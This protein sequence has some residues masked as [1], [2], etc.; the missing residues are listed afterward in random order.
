MKARTFTLLL[1]AAALAA[2]PASA[3]NGHFLHGVGAVNSA[4]GGAGVALPNDTLGALNLNPA[5]LTELDGNGYEF[6]A[7]YNKADNAVSSQVGP[8][9]GRTRESGS[10]PLIPA[11]GWT[12]HRQGSNLAYGVG[13]LGLAGF[14]VD[15]AQDPNNPIL[16]PQPHGFGRAYANYQFMKV[17]T[18]LAYRVNP[19]LSLGVALIASRATLTADPAGFAAPDCS[20][21]PSAACF[22]PHVNSSSAWGYGA[23]VGVHYRVSPL[24]AL[25]LSYS[26]EQRFQSFEWNAA[27][28]NPNLATFGAARRIRFKLNA[29]ETVV[30]GIALT[31]GPRLKVA[32]D[33][34][35]INYSHTTGFGDDPFTGQGLGWKSI[36]VFDVGAQ[37]LATQ[38]LALRLGYNRTQNAIPAGVAFFNVESPAVFKDH[39]TGGLG[40]RISPA[41]ELNL[42]YYRALRSRITGPLFGPGGPVPGASVT[43]EQ[44][45]SSVLAAFSFRQ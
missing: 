1:A 10:T 17:P 41:F 33:G 32:L 15:Y 16:A 9:S 7:E 18:T 42:A 35:W 37:F 31:P 14:G 2:L 28:A 8:F 21:P 25:G 12:Q 23:Q 43:D 5:L 4:M 44:S 22:I 38:R 30:A 45:L 39:V 29:P 6:S 34:K 3:G 27:V 20:G 19:A 40:L 36:G 26:T 13:F 24:L 11:F